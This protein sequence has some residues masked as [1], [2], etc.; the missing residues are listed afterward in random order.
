MPPKTPQGPQKR[1][2]MRDVAERCGVSIST[3]SLVLSGDPRIPEDTAKAVLQAVKALEYRPSVVARNLARRS[4][5][6]IAIILP[7]FAFSK[8]QPFYYQALAGIHAV[9]QAAGYKI[10]VEAANNSFLERRYYHRLLK[11]QSVDGVIYM[12]AEHKDV[13]LSEM[14]REPYPFLLMTNGVD[15]VS[16]ASAQFDDTFGASLA[17]QHL[18]ALGHTKIGYL[19]GMKEY[20]LGRDREKG[21][22]DG[23]KNAGLPVRDDWVV[24]TDLDPDKAMGATKKLAEAQVTAIFACHDILAYSAILALKQ[25]GKKVPEDVA[26]VGM[27]DLSMSEW[28]SPALTSVHYDIFSLAGTSAKYIINRIQSPLIDK[29]V[30]SDMPKPEIVIRGSCGAKK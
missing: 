26:I 20:S 2:R 19:A 25:V 6:T 11:E 10:V 9:T 5:R 28:T 29:K 1:V 15:G 7:E 4:S 12:A 30:L 21:F 24:E 16:L 22:R 23:M 8:N 14:S 27:D 18:A 13:F 3:V 17:V